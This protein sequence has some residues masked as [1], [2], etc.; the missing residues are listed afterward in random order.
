MTGAY[1]ERM[2]SFTCNFTLVTPHFSWHLTFDNHVAL[3]NRKTL[4]TQFTDTDTHLPSVAWRTCKWFYPCMCRRRCP[5]GS[6]SWTWALTRSSSRSWWR[7]RPRAIRDD[8]H[9]HDRLPFLPLAMYV[10]ISLCIYIC[11]YI[12]MSLWSLCRFSCHF[13]G[14]IVCVRMYVYMVIYVC[15]Y[16]SMVVCMSLCT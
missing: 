9:S 7:T 3:G 1:K 5:S 6:R 8:T 16:G 4:Y 15:T 12:C 14:M 10:C 2:L 13:V 11:M